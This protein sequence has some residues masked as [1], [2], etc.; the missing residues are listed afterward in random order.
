MPS[1][2]SPPPEPSRNTVTRAMGD[3]DFV[4]K[5]GAEEQDQRA[6]FR[7]NG[8]QDGIARGGMDPEFATI[9]RQLVRVQIKHRGQHPISVSLKGVQV[10][11][12]MPPGGVDGKMGFVVEQAHKQT[13]VQP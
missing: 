8:S 5:A 12:V 7:H 10:L 1:V 11:V 9:S 4:G 2:T 13:A 3:G 6:E